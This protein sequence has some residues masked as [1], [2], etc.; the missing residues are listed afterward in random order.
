MPFSDRTGPNWLGPKTG[1]GLGY[2]SGFRMFNIVKSSIS[3]TGFSGCFGF[4]CFGR[5]RG[6][7]NWYHETGLPG[8]IRFA[9]GYSALESSKHEAE[10]L[11]NQADFLRKQLD[12]IQD[13][14]NNLEKSESQEK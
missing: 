1:K 13:R 4:G 10:F 6:W 3:R 2:C 14:I 11:K 5:G 7:R 8:C 9:F 12:D